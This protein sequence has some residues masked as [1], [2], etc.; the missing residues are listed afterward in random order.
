[1]RRYVSIPGHSVNSFRS[2]HDSMV[3]ISGV[4]ARAVSDVND[5]IVAE[6]VPL[7]RNKRRK[8][9]NW[10]QGYAKQGCD[11][12]NGFGVQLANLQNRVREQDE[13]LRDD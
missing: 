1:M 9:E 3:G 6:S 10:E 7:M 12:Y 4:V 5:F 8:G 13:L 11:D 2:S